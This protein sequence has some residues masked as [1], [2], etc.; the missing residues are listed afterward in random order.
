MKGADMVT[1]HVVDGFVGAEDRY[2]TFASTTYSPD[3]GYINGYLGLTAAEDKNDDW[4]VISGS[5][6][7]GVT[8]VWLTRNRFT[9]DG[10]DRDVLIGLNRI[11]W[12]WSTVDTV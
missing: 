8:E 3:T 9:D 7:G 10:Q 6:E 4:T 11:I 5:E 1:A 12:A 2:A